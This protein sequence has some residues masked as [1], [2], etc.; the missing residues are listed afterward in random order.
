MIF[1]TK[2]QK[3]A[4]KN[5]FFSRHLSLKPQCLWFVIVQIDA[6]LNTSCNNGCNIHFNVECLSIS[7]F[8]VITSCYS[9]AGVRLF[10]HSVNYLYFG[11][12]KK[13][14]LLQSQLMQTFLTK[15]WKC[16]A[17]VVIELMDRQIFTVRRWVEWSSFNY[18]FIICSMKFD[19]AVVNASIYDPVSLQCTRILR[20]FQPVT[21]AETETWNVAVF[22]GIPGGRSPLPTLSLIAREI[23]Q[24][25][26]ESI[27]MQDLVWKHDAGPYHAMPDAVW[28]NL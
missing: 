26:R 3:K 27:G 9:N 25:R 11:Q 22:W 13:D 18:K 21:F 20:V 10:N 8:V 28:K 24:A 23:W 14:L 15:R 5:W 7:W 12:W 2:G 1:A 6:I 19:T 16:S 17:S 4:L